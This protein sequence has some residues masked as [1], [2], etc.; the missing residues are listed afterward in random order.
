MHAALVAPILPPLQP[1]EDFVVPI[2][3]VRTPEPYQVADILAAARSRSIS[4]HRAQGGGS[5]EAD[6]VEPLTYLDE[7]LAH[8]DAE[9]EHTEE[10]PISRWN[11]EAEEKV[12]GQDNT[13][14]T[15]SRSFASS[16]AGSSSELSTAAYSTSPPSTYG[17][18]YGYDDWNPD[19]GSSSSAPLSRS[20]SLASS[21]S[22]VGDKTYDFGDALSENVRESNSTYPDLDSST[23]RTS[24][25]NSLLHS[26]ESEWQFTSEAEPISFE[27]AVEPVSP[28]PL[29]ISD[30]NSQSFDFAGHPAQRRF[31]KVGTTTLES[32]KESVFQG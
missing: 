22:S 20:L 23:S 14:P 30:V 25:S 31:Q 7:P 5:P 28:G 17:Y 15:T 27:P 10:E 24:A 2:P 32:D 3:K 1:H 6:F 16:R 21:S 8:V 11:F 12:D 9:L 18:G 19:A 4:P 29:D 13:S 26:P